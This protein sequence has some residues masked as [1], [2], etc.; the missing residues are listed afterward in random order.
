MTVIRFAL[1]GLSLA[2]FCAVSA[3]A[4]R[5]GPLGGVAPAS[6]GPPF[7]RYLLRLLRLQVVV[8]GAPGPGPRVLAA[9][10]VS[11]LD[12][13]VLNSREPLC[14]LAKREVGTWPVV[15]AIA[16]AHGTVYV[17][18]TRRRSIPAANRALASRLC[19]GRSVLLFPEGTTHDGRR[20]GRFLT[21]HLACLRDRFAADAA[22]ESGAVQAATLSYS[23]P[24]AAWTGDA[25]L[26]PHLWA[27][28][29]GPPI[30]CRLSYGRMRRVVPGYDRKRLGADLARDVE[31]VLA[32]PLVEA[33]D[34]E[35]A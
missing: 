32:D 18:R 21:S 11:W 27:V 29:A 17:D 23:D 9:N 20:R 25:A 8:A 22:A 14:C 33:V 15:S 3:V 16:A 35:P 12:V 7:C 4:G 31:A 26:L 13:L 34:R 5:P 28:L 1:V 19:Q 30:V 10:H 2:A 6:L 24:A